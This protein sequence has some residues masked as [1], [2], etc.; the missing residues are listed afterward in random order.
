MESRKD[1]ALPVCGFV[2]HF[3]GTDDVGFIAKH[4]AVIAAE[5]KYAPEI[6]IFADD[7]DLD[8]YEVMAVG[9]STSGEVESYRKSV[10]VAAEVLTCV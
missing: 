9:V 1:A 8:R 7:T 10:Y 2:L 4:H 5:R 3:L 6:F